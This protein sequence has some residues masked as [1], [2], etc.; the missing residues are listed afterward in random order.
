M[1]YKTTLFIILAIVIGH[2]IFAVGWL[3]MKFRKPKK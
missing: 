2:F 1:E 3:I